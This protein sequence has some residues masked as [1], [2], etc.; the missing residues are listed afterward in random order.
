MLSIVAYDHA[1]TPTTDIF[2]LPTY[3]LQSN[4]EELAEQTVVNRY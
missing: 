4:F 2:W 1:E 3:W